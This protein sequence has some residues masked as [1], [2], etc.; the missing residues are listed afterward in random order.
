V[1][2][3][4]FAD[5]N[6]FPYSSRPG[7]SAAHFAGHVPDQVRA[8]RAA[9]L[10][11][12]VSTGYRAFRENLVGTTLPVLWEKSEPYEGLTDNYVR[13]RLTELSSSDRQ[14]GAQVKFNGISEIRLASFDGD[15]MLGTIIPT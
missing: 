10:R 8:E 15:R 12:A 2:R 9:R 11:E 6:V 4:G 13:V 3:S 14:A 7:T 5:A 1:D